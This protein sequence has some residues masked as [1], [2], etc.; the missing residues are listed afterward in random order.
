MTERV[1]KAV[2]SLICTAGLPFS[3]VEEPGFKNLLHIMQPQYKIR[4]FELMF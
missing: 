4:F 1:D 3:F 2:I